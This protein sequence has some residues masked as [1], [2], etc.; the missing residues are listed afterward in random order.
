[1]TQ[2]IKILS[3]LAKGKPLSVDQAASMLKVKNLRARITELRQRGVAIQ[4]TKNTKGKLS[5]ML[6]A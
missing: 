4:T 1:M 2:N 3:F 5:Y 6:V